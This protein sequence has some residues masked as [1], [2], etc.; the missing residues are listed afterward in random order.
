MFIMNLLITFPN[1]ELNANQLLNTNTGNNKDISQN[2]YA[3]LKKKK[4]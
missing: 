1:W 3:K 2:H 4:L